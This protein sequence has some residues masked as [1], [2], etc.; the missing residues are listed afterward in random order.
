MALPDPLG[1]RA[2]HVV[3][4]DARVL[5]AVRALQAGD[6]EALGA[7]FYASHDSMRDDYEVSVP[8]IDL[9]VELARAMPEVHGARLTGGGFGGSVV[10]L[11]RPG[12][13]ADVAQKVSAAY[14]AKTGRT[15][16]GTGA[17]ERLSA[18]GV[19]RRLTVA[20]WQ[21]ITRDATGH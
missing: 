4:E 2:R 11:A 9:I 14:T 5:A 21:S 6:L 12:T 16:D 7:L 15:G 3:T 10:M 20:S 17:V 19:S 18:T 8:E 1:R 13:A